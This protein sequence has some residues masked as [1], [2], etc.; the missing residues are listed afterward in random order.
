MVIPHE[1]TLDAKALSAWI[2]ANN[3]ASSAQMEWIT[4][5]VGDGKIKPPKG[6]PDNVSASTAKAVLDRAFGK[7]AGTASKKGRR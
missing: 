5:L 3:M 1:T 7:K 6:Y 4:K 2:D